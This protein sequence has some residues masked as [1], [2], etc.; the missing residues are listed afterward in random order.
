MDRVIS[1]PTPNSEA[2]E[3]VRP[4]PRGGMPGLSLVVPVYN[5]LENLR[6][7]LAR[8]R[9]TLDGYFAWRLIL[10]D[11]GS[12]D[13]SRDLVQE[14][15]DEDPQVIGVLLPHNCGQTSATATGIWHAKTELVATMD[16]DLQND[17][18]DLPALHG[19]LGDLDA[20]VG[21]RQKRNDTWVRRISSRVANRVRNR[22]TGDSIRD[23]GCSLK[24]FRR[25]PIQ[26]IPLFE[27]MHRFLPTLL[28]LHGYSVGEHPVS[29]HP[30]ER[31]ES[32][33]GIRN[34]LFKSMRDLIAVRWMG[35][36]AIRHMEVQ[37]V[38]KDSAEAR[39]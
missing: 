13:G 10:V 6:P 7:L 36:R 27:G 33:Y 1:D 19:A 26:S 12:T 3:T 21:W 16:A 15:A 11:D 30:R 2:P 20:V 14:L 32:K 24:L 39:G 25:E 35:R 31:G 23:T 4:A 29:H 18:V 34:R 28:R 8:V 5:E 38:A 22:L 9:E 17:P 37:V